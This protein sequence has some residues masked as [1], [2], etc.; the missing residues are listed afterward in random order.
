[1]KRCLLAAAEDVCLDKT[2][3]IKVPASLFFS[4]EIRE[5]LDTVTVTVD[6]I[7]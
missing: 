4:L 5:V 2:K 3:R 7:R 1:V 6:Y